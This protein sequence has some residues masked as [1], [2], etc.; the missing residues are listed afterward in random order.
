MGLGPYS[1][2]FQITAATVPSQPNAPTTTVDSSENNIIVAWSQPSNTGGVAITGYRIT[3]ETS[4][5]TYLQE[6][7]NCDGVNQSSIISSRT[8]TIPASVLRL[9]PFSLTTGT[10]VKAK[11]V[12]LNSIGDSTESAAG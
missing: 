11:V 1:D 10:S 6:T 9:S 3:I 7:A 2:S 5:N 4:S 8:C 12:A